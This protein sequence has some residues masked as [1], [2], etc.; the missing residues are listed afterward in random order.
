MRPARL[1]A[2]S[3][4]KTP[5]PARGF[6]LIELLVVMVMLALMSGLVVVSIGDSFQRKL[7]AEAERLQTVIAAASD[8]AIFTGNEL[9]I[10]LSDDNYRVLRF[11]RHAQVWQQ[12]DGRAF[13]PHNLP[14]EMVMRLEV[15][16]FAVPVDDVDR[17]AELEEI[18]I[19]ERLA[20]EVG[21]DA[22]SLRDAK[23][24]ERETPQLLMLSS[25][26][27]SVFEVLFEAAENAS[28]RARY[29]L[30]SDG[31]SLPRVRNEQSG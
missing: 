18:D 4:R 1:R 24:E 15:E 12:A 21:G 13:A 27:L 19:E 25:G 17:D 31:F 20:A 29:A 2:A 14:A 7:Q 26:E 10:L 28:E 5:P 22:D 23:L 6:T 3:I 8:E 30:R 11:D 9:G 16:G